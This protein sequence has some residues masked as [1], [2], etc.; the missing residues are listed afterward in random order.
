M[1][2]ALFAERAALCGAPLHVKSAGF[3]TEGEP[4]PKAVLVTMGRLGVDLSGHRSR[5]VTPD[6]L[7]ECDL[8][9]GMARS[10]IWDAALMRPEI[11]RHA[12]VI[13]ELARLN[14]DIG[15][16]TVDEPMEDWLGRLHD[17]RNHPEHRPNAKDEIPDPYGRRRG[18]HTKVARRLQELVLELGDCAFEPLRALSETRWREGRL[19]WSP[20]QD[21][22]QAGLM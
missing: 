19:I 6:M 13:G 1:A 3:V 17:C 4:P 22:D 11:I 8:V 16:R 9:I 15:G 5:L 21:G 20:T 2:E 14:R 7:A 12:F 18:V 10:H